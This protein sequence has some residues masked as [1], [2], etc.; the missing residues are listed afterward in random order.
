MGTVVIP[1]LVFR[2]Q[3][4][5]RSAVAIADGMQLGVQSALGTPDTPGRAQV[6]AGQGGED[7]VD[8]SG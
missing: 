1:H 4:D 7:A 5:D 3:Q 2:Q 6:S 8:S